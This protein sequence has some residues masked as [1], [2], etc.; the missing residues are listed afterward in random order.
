M[1]L[2]SGALTRLFAFEFGSFG[3]LLVRQERIDLGLG[4]RVRL[5]Y[6]SDLH[7][8]HWWTR[9]VPEQLRIVACHHR[10]DLI[11]LGGDLADSAAGL[12]L[13]RECVHGLREVAPVHV[14]PGNHDNRPGIANVRAVVETEGANWLPDRPAIDPIRI[15]G[16]LRR[17]AEMPGILCAH[18]PAVFPEAVRAGYRLILAGHLHG[19]QCVLATIK[20]RLY[21]A[22]WFHRWHGLRFREGGAVMLV[23]RGVADTLPF[24]F[25]CPREV[26]LCDID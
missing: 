4:R 23:S 21:P 20:D 18:Y 17:N 10:P 6:A 7:L 11:L 22:V 16:E 9:R 8:G 19:G 26:L 12:S 25:N 2:A 13:L 24:R 5:F 3:P 14:I 1:G 15:D